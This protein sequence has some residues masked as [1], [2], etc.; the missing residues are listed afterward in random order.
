MKSRLTA[1]LTREEADNFAK[2][3]AAATPLR[4]RIR[5]LLEKDVDSLYASMG[6]EEVLSSPS[7][8]Y[9]QADRIAQVKAYKKIISLLE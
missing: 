2:D 6:E 3:F 9:L 1:G 4:K 7:W 5:E 8:P